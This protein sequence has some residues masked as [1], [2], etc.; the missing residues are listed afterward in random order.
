M[1]WSSLR[2]FR[3]RWRL[4]GV[5]KVSRRRRGI[6]V[7]WEEF[8]GYVLLVRVGVGSL[9]TLRTLR[10]G[11]L[12][13]DARGHGRWL[14]LGRG[15]PRRGPL[16]P[17]RRCEYGAEPIVSSRRGGPVPLLEQPRDLRVALGNLVEEH[18]RLALKPLD[19]NREALALAPCAVKILR[20]L[21]LLVP[22]GTQRPLQEH[23]LI[24]LPLKRL[25]PSLGAEQVPRVESGANFGDAPAFK[26]AFA[27]V[28]R[29]CECTRGMSRVAPRVK[30]SCHADRAHAVN[31]LAQ[32]GAL[33]RRPVCF[34]APRAKGGGQCAVTPPRA[35]PRE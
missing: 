25:S 15:R 23:E 27:P 13:L 28:P 1:R 17:R 24:R 35:A 5:W 29:A 20:N 4:D 8:A 6:V 18:A 12:D 11:F 32:G 16:L 10:V 9:R 3:S 19:E 7:R 26:H 2:E 21:L 31:R 14:G 33:E 30:R 34:E 22:L